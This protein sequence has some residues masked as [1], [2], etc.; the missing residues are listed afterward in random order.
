MK[1]DG[2]RLLSEPQECSSNYWLQTIILPEPNLDLRNEILASLNG[3]GLMSRPAWTGIHKLQ[4]FQDCPR[5][6]MSTTDCLE[7]RIINIPS[8]S[9]LSEGS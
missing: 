8:S 6:D 2:I 9:F 7:K 5:M 1:L 4:H 3:E